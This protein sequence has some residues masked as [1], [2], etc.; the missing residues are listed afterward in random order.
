[1]S[2]TCNGSKN[3]CEGERFG[4]CQ[5]HMG[6]DSFGNLLPSVRDSLVVAALECGDSLNKSP[7]E[8]V[9]W[10]RDIGEAALEEIE[11]AEK[12]KDSTDESRNTA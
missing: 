9:Q 6:L 10:L 7:R 8:M 11:E 2:Y 4:G 12:R 5:W 3:G 1:M